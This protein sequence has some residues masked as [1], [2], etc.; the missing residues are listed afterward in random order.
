MALP[1]FRPLCGKLNINCTLPTF[2]LSPINDLDMNSTSVGVRNQVA[3]LKN[4]TMLT[5]RDSAAITTNHTPMAT[6]V[7]PTLQ[8]PQPAL[9]RKLFVSPPPTTSGERTTHRPINNSKTASGKET[10]LSSDALVSQKCCDTPELISVNSTKPQTVDPST[11]SSNRECTVDT[12]EGQLPR[13]CLSP[14]PVTSPSS[15]AHPENDKTDHTYIR[16]QKAKKSGGNGIRHKKK[17]K[18]TIVTFVSKLMAKK[19]T[20]HLTLKERASINLAAKEVKSAGD[21]ANTI[22]RVPALRSALIDKLSDEA[23]KVPNKMRNTKKGEISV[24]MQKTVKS[25][26]KCQ[27]MHVVGE[28]HAKFPELFQIVLKMMSKSE[29]NPDTMRPLIPRLAMVYGIV[30]QTRYSSL[31]LVQRVITTSLMD[32]ICNQKV[33][34]LCDFTVS[35][36]FNY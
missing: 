19:S 24:L 5:P 34:Y 31:S 35:T 36:I 8:H 9:A 25:L 23:G 27:L 4:Q 29:L 22:L 15:G 1:L 13:E 28:F 16:Q 18:D 17:V 10:L 6:R 26:E 30:M 33:Y 11:S 20:P 7:T 3:P 14:S 32:Q 2:Q 21:I 12:T